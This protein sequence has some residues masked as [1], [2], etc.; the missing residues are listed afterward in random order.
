MYLNVFIKRFLNYRYVL[1]IHKRFYGAR[2][3]DW[4]LLNNVYVKSYLLLRFMS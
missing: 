1:D 3:V 4:Y 2:E